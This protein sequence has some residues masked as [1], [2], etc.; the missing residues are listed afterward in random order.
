MTRA[1][2]SHFS[3]IQRDCRSCKIARWRDTRAGTR[4][5]TGWHLSVTAQGQE[6]AL[7]IVVVHWPTH[8]REQG[9]QRGHMAAS[10]YRE[11]R[12]SRDVVIVGDFNDEP[13][14]EALSDG[15]VACRD[16]DLVRQ[17]EEAFY[18]PFWRWLGD[19]QHG[20]D[21]SRRVPAGRNALLQEG[22][23]EPL[24]HLR[25]GRRLERP[26]WSERMAAR[27]TR[28]VG[29]ATRDRH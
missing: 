20:E 2:P 24:V 23:L 19:R 27:G 7:D 1:M 22:I 10:L 21:E 8:H 29:V 16:R 13:F 4:F 6:D 17:K 12:R 5:E 28:H 25:S 3:T 11:F 9:P 26:A 15:L 14:S 18:N